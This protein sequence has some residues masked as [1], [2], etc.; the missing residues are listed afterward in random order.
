VYFDED[1]HSTKYDTLKEIIVASPGEPMLILTDSQK[2]AQ[3]V[4]HK[5][6]QD[7]YDALEWSG[8]IPQGMREDIKTAFVAGRLDYIVA[9]IASIGEGVDGLQHRSRMM[10]WLSRSDNNM[11]N[12]QAF[13]RLYRRGQER[14]VVSIDIEAKDT[15]DTG[16]LSSLVQQQIRNNEI[17]RS[18]K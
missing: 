3:V 4:T 15:Y 5:L 12:Q 18:N 14:T 7:G 16:V 17:L 6:R 9:T 1:M 2:Y 8:R 13:R 11:L 10:V